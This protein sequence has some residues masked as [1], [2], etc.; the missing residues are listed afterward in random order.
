MSN[1]LE[2][3]KRYEGCSL[4]AYLCPAHKWTIGY[5]VTL[6]PDG[7][8]VKEGDVI[9]QSKADALLLDY[10]INNILPNIKELNLSENQTKALVSLLYNIG[11][12]AFKKSKCYKA[13]KS[14]DWGTAFREW[15]WITGGGKVLNGLIKRRAEEMAL[16]FGDI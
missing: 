14:K 2:M 4:T 1:Y 16:F 12:T 6:Y 10:V 7:T 15:N 9:T 3:I 11:I 5:G 13:I 8:P